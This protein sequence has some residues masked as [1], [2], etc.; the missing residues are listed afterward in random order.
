MWISL[1]VFL[2][3]IKNIT[4]LKL[5][6][7]FVRQNKRFLKKIIKINQ[8]KII[9]NLGLS[10]VE[11]FFRIFLKIIKMKKFFQMGL[12]LNRWAKE[13]NDTNI[14]KWYTIFL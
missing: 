5:N 12:K 6:S 1:L 4:S 10:R 13:K 9:L 8:N 7:C 3:I 14:M 2:S 11:M